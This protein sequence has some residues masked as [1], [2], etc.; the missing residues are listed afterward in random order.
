MRLQNFFGQDF[1][2]DL[3]IYLDARKIFGT[4]NYFDNKF[5]LRQKNI[6]DQKIVSD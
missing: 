1:F 3:K 6:L 5:F 2:P 4:Q